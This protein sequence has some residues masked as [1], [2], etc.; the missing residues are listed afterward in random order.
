MLW[1]IR[2]NYEAT[3]GQ[4]NKVYQLIKRIL[5]AFMWIA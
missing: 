4:A 3:D 5:R 1:L 2:L